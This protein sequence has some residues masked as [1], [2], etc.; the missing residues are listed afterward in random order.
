MIIKIRSLRFAFG[1]TNGEAFGMTDDKRDYLMTPAALPPRG[2]PDI[3]D[4][5]ETVVRLDLRFH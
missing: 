5:G 4:G 2:K 3:A 1:M